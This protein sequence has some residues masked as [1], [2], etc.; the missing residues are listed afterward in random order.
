[1]GKL[2]DSKISYV[3]HS[4]MVNKKALLEV[5]N[6]CGVKTCLMEDTIYSDGSQEIKILL[7]VPKEVNKP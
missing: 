3:K 4:N 5:M 2:I 7:S 6:K 1:M